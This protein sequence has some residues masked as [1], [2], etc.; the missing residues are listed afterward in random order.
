MFDSLPRAHDRMNAA[1]S[2]TASGESHVDRLGIQSFLHLRT[3]QRIP[4]RIE[5][6]LDLTFNCVY[7]GAI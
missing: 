6:F 1:C 5:R 7:S 3:C 2:S 4:A